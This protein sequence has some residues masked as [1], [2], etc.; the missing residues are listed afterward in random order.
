MKHIKFLILSSVSMFLFA[1][2]A[3]VADVFAA[4]PHFTPMS[5]LPQPFALI[6]ILTKQ[7]LNVKNLLCRVDGK[8]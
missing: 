5:L 3:F 1:S 4:N 8:V 6:F 2:V 7:Q